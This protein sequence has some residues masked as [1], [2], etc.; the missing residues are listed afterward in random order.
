MSK[1]SRSLTGA[2]F[3]MMLTLGSAAVAAGQETPVPV[4]EPQPPAEAQEAQPA[5]PALPPAPAEEAQAPV[6]VELS[7]AQG[8]GEATLSAAAGDQADAVIEVEGLEPGTQY[9]A[10][11]ISGSC[12]SPGDVVAPLGTVAVA[13][14]GSGR[15]E[16][17][18]TT[19]LSE[20]AQG[21]ATVQIHP[22][23]DAPTEA[24]LCGAVPAVEA[25]PSLPAF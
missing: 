23:G 24:V 6:V 15:G 10:F 13:D 11:L 8:S 4:P 14:Q 19:P 1:L 12:D 2:S 21:E 16:V 5:Q 18:L 20:L 17:S 25:G 3:A 9:S 22:Q 7:G